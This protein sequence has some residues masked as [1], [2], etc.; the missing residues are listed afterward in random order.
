MHAFKTILTLI[1]LSNLSIYAQDFTKKSI[2]HLDSTEQEMY[3]ILKLS[4]EAYLTDTSHLQL[5]ST[6]GFKEAGNKVIVTTGFY[7]YPILNYYGD[8][9]I[10][11]ATHIGQLVFE[12]AFV[13]DSTLVYMGLGGQGQNTIKKEPKSYR[14]TTHKK[15]RHPFS[16]SPYGPEITRIISEKPFFD[17]KYKN[18]AVFSIADAKNS[19]DGYIYSHSPDSILLNS[20][21]YSYCTKA[22]AIVKKEKQ[23]GIIGKGNRII[24]PIDKDYVRIYNQGIVVKENAKEYFYD[25][26]TNTKTSAA[27]DKIKPGFLTPFSSK[28]FGYSKVY[29]NG[30]VTI[31]NMEKRELAPFIY[32]DLRLLHHKDTTV[33]LADRDGG[34]VLLN[35]QTMEEVSMIYDTLQLYRE[36]LLLAKSDAKYGFID[37]KGKD[38]LSVEYDEVRP[39]DLSYIYYVLSKNDKKALYNSD[40]K[41]FVTEFAYAEMNMEGNLIVV[42][43]EEKVGLMDKKGDLVIPIKYDRIT[44][45]KKAS[46]YLASKRKKVMK[47]S[48]RGVPIKK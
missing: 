31:I 20:Y 39:M 16:P 2:S 13:F 47:F 7:N 1:L 24:L 34:Q 35:L 15:D 46:V 42:K 12:K 4:I 40:T 11:S 17:K 41:E 8:Q 45:D 28:L 19:S 3:A 14:F 10:K 30:F 33:L 25:P 48:K 36:D 29:N 37:K 5:F 26:L 18:R 32:T 44:Y 9:R 38:I 21:Y 43:K 23:Y 22:Y 27:Y 6:V